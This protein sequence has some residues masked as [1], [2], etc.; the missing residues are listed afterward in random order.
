MTVT[1]L[2]LRRQALSIW[3]I[4]AFILTAAAI[5]GIWTVSYTHLK[6]M[7]EADCRELWKL[8]KEMDKEFREMKQIADEWLMVNGRKDGCLGACLLYT[9]DITGIDP[10]HIPFN[11]EKTLSLF[12]SSDALGITSEQLKAAVGDKGCLLYTSKGTGQI[13]T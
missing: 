7:S 12:S 11:D 4:T 8:I 3:R 6:E 5:R 9:S 13:E 2:M 10:L 1:F